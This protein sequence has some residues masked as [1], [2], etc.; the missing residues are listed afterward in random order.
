M[1]HVFCCMFTEVNGLTHVCITGVWGRKAGGVISNTRK[2]ATFS[3][4]TLLCVRKRKA[5]VILAYK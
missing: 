5:F 4:F 3:P 2:L 1:T